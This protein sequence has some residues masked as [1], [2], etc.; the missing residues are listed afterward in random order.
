MRAQFD[1]K[2]LV[3]SA[4]L[5]FQLWGTGGKISKDHEEIEVKWYAPTE[6]GEMSTVIVKDISG[7]YPV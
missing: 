5:Q 6:K 7:M 2:V 1:L 4:D 3:G